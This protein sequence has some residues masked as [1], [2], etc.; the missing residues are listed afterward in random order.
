MG[1]SENLILER[2]RSLYLERIDSGDQTLLEGGQL[3]GSRLSDQEVRDLREEAVLSL[4]RDRSVDAC[5][6]LYEESLGLDIKQAGVLL[7]SDPLSPDPLSSDPLSPDPLFVVGKDALTGADD[8]RKAGAHYTPEELVRWV[9][10]PTLARAFRNA[11]SRGTLDSL[12]SLDSYKRFL[13]EITI[14]DPAMGAGYFLIAAAREV[15]TELA[16]VSIFGE[17]RFVTYPEWGLHVFGNG[18]Y[19]CPPE[20]E[21]LAL[22][23]LPSVYERS[24]YGVDKSAVAP[25]IASTLVQR[26]VG[27]REVATNFKT[28]DALIGLMPQDLKR[29]R[30]VLFDF[31]EEEEGD[32]EERYDTELLRRMGFE[33]SR[34]PDTFHWALEFPEVF[35]RGGFDV[36]LANPPFIGDRKLREF[37]GPDGYE[38][39]PFLKRYYVSNRGTP[40]YSGFFLWRIHHLLKKDTGLVGAVVTNSITQASNYRIVFEPLITGS[41]F[42]LWGAAKSLPWPQDASVTVSLLYMSRQKPDRA[43]LLQPN[44]GDQLRVQDVPHIS[45]HLDDLPESG[46]LRKLKV[47]PIFFGGI[48]T[49][50]SFSIHRQPGQDL[51]SAIAVVPETERD[52][53]RYYINAR[54]LQQKRELT[55]SDVV[56]DFHEVLQ[57][58]GLK[59]AS[60]QL[61]YLETNYPVTLSY[62]RE[63]SPHSPHRKSVFEMRSGLDSYGYNKEHIKYW[64]LY[65][66][67]HLSLRQLLKR[68]TE[69]LVAPRSSKVWAPIRIPLTHRKYPLYPSDAL[70]VLNPEYA[71]ASPI[72]TSFLFELFARQRGSSLQTTFRFSAT[73]IIPYFPWPSYSSGGQKVEAP[74]PEVQER[75]DKAL[76]RIMTLRSTILQDPESFGLEGINGIT[77]LYNC[78]DNPAL[79]GVEIINQLRQAHEALLDEV[80]LLYGW[81]DLVASEWVF[82]RPWVDQSPRY[83]PPHSIRYA[84]LDRLYALNIT[85]FKD[86]Q[87]REPSYV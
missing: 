28:G 25:Q 6:R 79:T 70:V 75:L 26:I 41:C 60:E 42:H 87:Q 13:E 52:V 46:A 31:L 64:F 8:R 74:S 69:V 5:G 56:I 39:L 34:P 77:S 62:L 84:I 17:P 4:C 85:R 67:A 24:I 14:C 23:H 3:R 20:V 43:F 57:E 19:R 59:T 10:I 12:D 55:P 35:S 47:P 16:W 71:W 68:E 36:V 27:G 38:A 7:S 21:E 72:L 49:R 44:E 22:E 63:R 80:L 11:W 76:D 66:S 29:E 58:E 9:T 78:Y 1:T 50:G 83:V 2:M 61:E 86:Q 32:E 82:D 65:S 48:H 53:L 51:E 73:E 30:G 54:D 40:D 18:T 33:K 37:L 45:S 15:A 81:D